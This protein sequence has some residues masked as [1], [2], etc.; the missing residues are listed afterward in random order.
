MVTES[1]Q[2]FFD[3]N[4]QRII[5]LIQKI[6]D[7]VNVVEEEDTEKE[8]KEITSELCDLLSSSSDNAAKIYRYIHEEAKIHLMNIVN[9]YC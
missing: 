7:F 2:K 8:L 3:E 4:E 1:V 6:T 9:R 5:K